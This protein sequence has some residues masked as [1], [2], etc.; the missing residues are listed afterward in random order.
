M[1]SV[2]IGATRCGDKCEKHRFASRFSTCSAT[3]QERSWIRQGSQAGK[4]SVVKILRPFLLPFPGF[5]ISSLDDGTGLFLTGLVSKIFVL[6]ALSSRQEVIVLDKQS[7]SVVDVST[8]RTVFQQTNDYC[9]VVLMSKITTLARDPSFNDVRQYVCC[10][11]Q[12]SITDSDP[13]GTF[14]VDTCSSIG[15]GILVLRLFVS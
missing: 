11:H 4:S 14:S 1:R 9:S 2:L 5:S 7:D 12:C 10:C 8:R 15:A 6:D 13:H 3:S